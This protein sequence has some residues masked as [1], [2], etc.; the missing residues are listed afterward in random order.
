VLVEIERL[1]PAGILCGDFALLDLLLLTTMLNGVRPLC[2]PRPAAQTSA[3]SDGTV[4]EMLPQ[5]PD[6]SFLNQNNSPYR[7]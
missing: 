7:P 6:G 2:L 4:A 1:Q 5:L 3:W